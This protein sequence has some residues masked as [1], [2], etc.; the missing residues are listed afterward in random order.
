[1]FSS[2]SALSHKEVHPDLFY[3]ELSD[4]RFSSLLQCQ[5]WNRIKLSGLFWKYCEHVKVDL[6][7]SVASELLVPH[8]FTLLYEG[9][10]VSI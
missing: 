9:F 7:P 3:S 8:P 6:C 5:G 4:N 1:M 10:F 2:L